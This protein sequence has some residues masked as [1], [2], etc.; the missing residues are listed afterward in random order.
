MDSFIKQVGLC[1][2]GGAVLGFVVSGGNPVVA[3][4]TAKAG[5]KFGACCGLA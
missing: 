5:A 2:L 4:A 1:A 3:V